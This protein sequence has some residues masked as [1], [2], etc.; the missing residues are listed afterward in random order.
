MRAQTI[1]IESYLRKHG[2]FVVWILNILVYIAD[3]FQDW[4]W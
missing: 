4:V 2:L 3:R 1:D